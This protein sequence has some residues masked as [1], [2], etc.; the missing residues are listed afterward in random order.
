M[1]WRAL[2]FCIGVMGLTGCQE[3][4]QPT[5]ILSPRVSTL[6]ATEITHNSALVGGGNS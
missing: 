5:P 6:G 1:R 2:L 3:E 4:E